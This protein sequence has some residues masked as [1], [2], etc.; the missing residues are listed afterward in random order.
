MFTIE[1]DLFQVIERI[2]GEQQGEPDEMDNPLAET[3]E[4]ESDLNALE[5]ELGSVEGES[6][7]SEPN[8]DTETDEE[9]AELEDETP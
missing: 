1:Q 8:E 3:P 7:P 6:E 2:D 9:S 4:L 5:A